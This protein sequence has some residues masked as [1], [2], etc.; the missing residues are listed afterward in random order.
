MRRATQVFLFIKDGC[1]V[2][3]NNKNENTYLQE[4][5]LFSPFFIL[6]SDDMHSNDMCFIENMLKYL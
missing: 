6:K 3:N 4:F 5:F 2:T 1:L